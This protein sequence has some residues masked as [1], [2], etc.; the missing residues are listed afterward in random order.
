MS[1]YI[2]RAEGTISFA[3]AVLVDAT[4][5][6]LE[7]RAEDAVRAA[8]AAQLVYHGCDP[9]KIDIEYLDINK[10]ELVPCG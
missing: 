7:E 2:A 4:E 5:A 6:D 9:S 10:Q 8:I 3:V 1:A